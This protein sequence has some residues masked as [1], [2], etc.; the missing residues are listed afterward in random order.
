MTHRFPK[1]TALL[2]VMLLGPG[3][4]ALAAPATI[5]EL[6]PVTPGHTETHAAGL[7]NQAQVVGHS[8]AEVHLGGAVLRQ[9]LPAFWNT[10]TGPEG[11]P[12][13]GLALPST[14]DSHGTAVAI[15]DAGQ[16]AGSYNG[17]AYRWTPSSPGVYANA[18]LALGMPAE[19]HAHSQ[20][21]ADINSQG[22]V[23]GSYWRCA[24]DNCGNGGMGNTRAWRWDTAGGVQAIGPHS[25][26]WTYAQAIN[27]AGD[28]LVANTPA[29]N[30]RLIQIIAADG[31]V[32]DV[33]LPGHISALDVT[34]DMN[35][36]RQI[37]ATRFVG[38][39]SVR[40]ALVWSEGAEYALSHL[41]PGLGG[42]ITAINSLGW[43]V[44]SE[45]VSAS[46]WVAALWVGTSLVFDLNH[47]LDAD[48][49]ELWRLTEAVDINDQGWL[50][51]NGWYRSTVNA[52]YQRRG[53]LLQLSADFIGGLP[54]PGELFPP[55]SSPVPLPG[56]L[57][58][59]AL[60]LLLTVTR[61]QKA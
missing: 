30:S 49:A 40:Q 60:A 23:V 3:A 22:S 6:A 28:T 56:T 7:N 54:P 12:V 46:D 25:G 38:D 10:P 2:A 20:T 42:R 5:Y 27:N 44:G 36:Q 17:R 19:P 55:P 43:V 52:E 26:F 1:R 37:A 31:T 29:N 32:T 57:A 58:L 59:T 15:N 41:A 47:L 11:N 4:A 48:D 24:F 14:L 39:G 45:A 53:F 51:G 9:S 21:A 50:T 61:R 34:M 33:P 16:V 35:D 8:A 13:P 18:G